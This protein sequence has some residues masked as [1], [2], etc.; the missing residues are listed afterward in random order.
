MNSAKI[1][2]SNSLGTALATDADPNVAPGPGDDKTLMTAALGKSVG[3]FDGVWAMSLDGTTCSLQLWIWE[4]TTKRWVLL[5]AAVAVAAATG[6]VSLSAVVPLQ[7][8]VF[9]QITA[10]TGVIRIAIG[11]NSG[12]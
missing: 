11:T 5:G 4:A 6:M 10:N 2:R 3:Q 9:A 12:A 1:L 7:T 8:K